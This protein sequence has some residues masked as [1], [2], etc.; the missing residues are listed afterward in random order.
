MASAEMEWWLNLQPPT[1]RK[2][3]TVVDREQA[4][5]LLH[6]S[7]DGGIKK[8]T[9]YVTR[10]AAD[11]E[12]ISVPRVSVATSILGCFIGYCMA[13]EDIFWPDL[14]NKAFK[15]G[16]YVYD[17][18]YTEALKPN[19][20]QLYD[21][22]MSD[23][24]WLVTYNEQTRTYP[25]VIKAKMFF[26]E[27]TIHPVVGKHPRRSVKLLIEV[28]G[29]SMVFA[30]KLPLAKGYWEVTGPDPMFVEDWRQAKE[31]KTRKLS[32]GEWGV[33]KK[34]TADMLSAPPPPAFSW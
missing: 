8:F 24:H 34:L 29:D 19:L 33:A 4:G 11:S 31:F 20:K 14:R 18:P 9:P 21:Q 13:F 27:I 28:L 1:I 30:D 22:E 7:I 3:L 10:R 6:M 15:N 17:I 25:A 2:A 16:W 26:S 23:E 12:N 32:A 5:P